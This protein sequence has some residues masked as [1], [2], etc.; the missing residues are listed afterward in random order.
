LR[1]LAKR[2]KRRKTMSRSHLLW[3]ALGV[4]LSIGCV[5]LAA[6][7]RP[8]FPTQARVWIENRAPSEAIPV[9]WIQGGEVSRVE[10]VGTRS[11]LQV[12]LTRQLWDYKSLQIAT[13]DDPTSV[14]QRQGDDGWELTGIQIQRPGDVI[15]LLKRPR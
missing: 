11:P 6:Q 12:R 7:D 1:E 14:L 8:G 2:W 5:A 13:G 15:V 3:T 4:A 10:V 9:R